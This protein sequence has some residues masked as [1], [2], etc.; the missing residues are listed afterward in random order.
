MKIALVMVMI[1]AGALG[2]QAQN[3]RGNGSCGMCA[4]SGVNSTKLTDEQ[5]SILLEK[6]TTFQAEMNTLRAKMIASATVAE[7][8]SI[9]QDM[10]SM[11][12]AHIQEVKDLLTSWGVTISTGNGGRRGGAAVGCDGSGSGKG[13]GRR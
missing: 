1:A 9:R 4:G 5:K 11:R 3:G 2:L 13:R 7:K 8:L 6:C 10:T 12:T